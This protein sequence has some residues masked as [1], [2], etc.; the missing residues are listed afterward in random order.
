MP[1]E[2]RRFSPKKIAQSLCPLQKNEYQ[3]QMFECNESVTFQNQAECEGLK[4]NGVGDSSGCS[5]SNKTAHMGED[6]AKTASDTQQNS[7]SLDYTCPN[8]LNIESAEGIL[9]SQSFVQPRT[10]NVGELIKKSGLWKMSVENKEKILLSVSRPQN[11]ET[12][13]NKA[14]STQ[15]NQNGT[16]PS[17]MQ[18]PDISGQ[19]VEQANELKCQMALLDQLHF[20]PSNPSSLT[21]NCS[22]QQKAGLSQE[23]DSSSLSKSC[24]ELTKISRRPASMASSDCLHSRP[25]YRPTQV[26]HKRE[27]MLASSAL[28]PAGMQETKSGR[29]KFKKKH[30]GCSASTVFGKL[31]ILF[32]I[33]IAIMKCNVKL[34]RILGLLKLSRLCL[35]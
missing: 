9:E 26:D 11:V 34:F 15:C 14:L 18:T 3:N 19:D 20:V 32:F 4:K 16:G 8:L 12:K 5:D 13:D 24:L 31:S 22:P 2:E 28:M 6:M 35:N 29:S 23:R 27:N 17:I 7:D 10:Q 30:Q 25:L 33:C 1:A 21:K